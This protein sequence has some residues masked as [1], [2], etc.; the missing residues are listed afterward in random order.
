M[1]CHGGGATVSAVDACLRGLA[2]QSGESLLLG[3]NLAEAR[4][5]V[6]TTPGSERRTDAAAK[7]QAGQRRRGD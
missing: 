5:R 6:T 2:G 4:E 3:P 1:T 7:G